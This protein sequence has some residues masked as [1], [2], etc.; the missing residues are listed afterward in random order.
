MAS[1]AIK[2]LEAHMSDE[3]SCF[4]AEAK[5]RKENSGWLRWSR[6]LANIEDKLGISCLLIS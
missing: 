4:V 2:F 6:Q 1:R 3:P 5:R